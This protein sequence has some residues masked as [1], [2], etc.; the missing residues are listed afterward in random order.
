MNE[1]ET[2]KNLLNKMY[3]EPLNETEYKV[4][5]YLLTKYA[6]SIQNYP[7]TYRVINDNKIMF[8]SDNHAG[9]AKEDET[10]TLR[11]LEVADKYNIRTIV[12]GGDFIEGCANR[13]YGKSSQ[14]IL[15]EL[16]K[17][18]SQIPDNI[19]I[20]LLLGNHDF[21]AFNNCSS[22]HER[23]FH[24]PKLDILGL[25]KVLLYWNNVIKIYLHH[26][27]SWLK[28]EAEENELKGDIK[29]LGHYHNFRLDEESK[30]IYLPS[31]CKD[32]T[33]ISLEQFGYTFNTDIEPIFLVATIKDINT[34]LFEA[35]SKDCLSTG[36]LT[37][38]DTIEYDT[39]K[40]TLKKWK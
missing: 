21:S 29:I 27:V 26:K 11:A 14:T 20:K 37:K 35:F 17:A 25:N 16:D 23:L 7:L 28:T 40:K 39:H 18:L 36:K 1:I 38:R 13:Q 9:G 5:Q 4:L 10:T 34:I 3:L 31:L 33:Q 8:M 24:E 15:N 30:S 6:R 2:M 12:H 19:T 22:L 32:D